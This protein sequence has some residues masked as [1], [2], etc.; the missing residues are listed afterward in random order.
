MV[1][2]NIHFL[3]E[4]EAYP[5]SVT[6]SS[7]NSTE[8]FVEWQHIPDEYR[9]GI[10]LG[11]NVSFSTNNSH[12]NWQA[13]IVEPS[14]RYTTLSGLEKFTWYEI[15]VAGFTSKGLG[16]ESP[17]IATRTKEDGEF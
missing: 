16:P 11:Y 8:L 12:A 17:P 7:P 13:K 14:V 3:T 9:N 4:P 6:C 5:Q 10:L 1:F 2:R 15:Q